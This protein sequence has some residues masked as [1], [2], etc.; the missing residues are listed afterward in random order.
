MCITATAMTAVAATA[1]AIGRT[2][3]SVLNGIVFVVASAAVICDGIITAA[4]AVAATMAAAIA[5]VKAAT[6]Q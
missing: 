4:A 5:G 2:V 6:A 3:Q 1:S